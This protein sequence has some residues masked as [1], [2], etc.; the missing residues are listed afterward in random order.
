[1]QH[2]IDYM[3]TN[4][5]T[6]KL[7]KLLNICAIINDIL[8]RILNLKKNYNIFW[9]CFK[10]IH[11]VWG[12]SKK[13]HKNVWAEGV[14]YFLSFFGGEGG[15]EGGREDQWE[16]WN[17]SCDM[18]ANERPW[19]KLHRMAQ[20]YTDRRTWRLYD[21]IGPVRSIHWKS[22]I[23]ETLNPST[24]VD[25]IT[26]A[27]KKK[28]PPKFF[29]RGSKKKFVRSPFFGGL[30]FFLYGGRGYFRFFCWSISYNIVA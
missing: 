17:W 3:L 5:N 21:W 29:L 20:T 9:Y 4:I 12:V 22:R 30:I 26:I 16:A 24:D 18:R 13:Q 7:C 28:G 10:C 1:M 23:Q 2:R 25:S 19:Q 8:Y 6:I 11:F 15:A 27:M 14:N